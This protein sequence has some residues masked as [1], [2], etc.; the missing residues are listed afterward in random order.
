MSVEERL[1]RL[2]PKTQSFS[3]SG[4]GFDTMSPQELAACLSG[5]PP[6]GE[7]IVWRRYVDDRTAPGYGK[8]T[9]LRLSVE[10]VVERFGKNKG[11]IP[12]MLDI[13]I[14]GY[15][16]AH[17]CPKC[18]GRQY[19]TE[20]GIVIKCPSIRC[21]DGSINLKGAEIARMLDITYD[22]WRDKYMAIYQEID[23]LLTEVIPEAE[24][25]TLRMVIR[26]AGH[27]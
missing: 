7:Y 3:D 8:G 11:L 13:A 14:D 10:R 18:G 16:G 26:R 23:R 6:I 24:A 9:L 25:E 21:K 1:S 5:S 22:Q 17:K 15:I 27:D 19:E 4:G 20:R 12:E 2:T